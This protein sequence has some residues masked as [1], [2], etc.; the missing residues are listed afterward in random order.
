[1]KPARIEGCG[2]KQIL[3]RR[4]PQAQVQRPSNVCR[5]FGQSG[6]KVHRLCAQTSTCATN[7]ALS[8]CA[9]R[10]MA[11]KGKSSRCG[12]CVGCQG[13][14][15]CLNQK[16]LQLVAPPTRAPLT[17]GS[18]DQQGRSASATSDF[19]SDFGTERLNPQM[20]TEPAAGS[21][22]RCPDTLPLGCSRCIG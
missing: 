22:T 4:E 16:K 3:V 13:K 6:V 5:K 20:M 2:D 18:A 14:R 10:S 15:R 12:S 8:C 1:M 21:P 19:G 9:Y 11:P 17:R 7:L